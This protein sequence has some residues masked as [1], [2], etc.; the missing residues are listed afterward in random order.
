MHSTELELNWARVAVDAVESLADEGNGRA[1]VPASTNAG[2]ATILVKRQGGGVHQTGRVQGQS[3]HVKWG[4]Q[5]LKQEDGV[6]RPQA[7]R[8]QRLPTTLRYR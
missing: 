2:T 5:A 4:W 3:L 1:T 8:T 6:P 7:Q